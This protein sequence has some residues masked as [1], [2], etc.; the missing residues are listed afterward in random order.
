MQ[1]IICSASYTFTTSG[2][3]FSVVRRFEG[4]TREDGVGDGQDASGALR[5][6]FVG[7]SREAW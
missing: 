3:A 6:K 7:C 1:I 5:E 2:P 4:K